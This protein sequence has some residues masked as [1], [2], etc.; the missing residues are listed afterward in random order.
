MNQAWFH[1]IIHLRL[2]I[3]F[4]YAGILILKLYEN[5]KAF[6]TQGYPHHMEL[7]S[8]INQNIRYSAYDLTLFIHAWGIVRCKSVN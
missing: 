3:I 8:V 6:L 5:T 7:Y 1:I 4:G 2:T